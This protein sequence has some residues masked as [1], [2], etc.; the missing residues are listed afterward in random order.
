MVIKM[1]STTI[2]YLCPNCGAAL[3]YDAEKQKFSCEFCFSDFDETELSVSG[4]ADAADKKE[5]D[6]REFCDSM[7][8][9]YC[10]NCGADVIADEHTVANFCYYCH[11]PVILR[12][13][14]EG[15]FKPDKIIPFIIDKERAERDFLKYAKKKW[16]APSDFSDADHASK[17]SGIYYPFWVTDADTD[18]LLDGNAEKVR[19]WTS[20]NYRVTETSRYKVRRRGDIHFEDITSSAYSDADKEML[21]GILP[22]P[23]D[24]H[25]EFSMPY[26]LGFEAKKRDVERSSLT[27]EVRER[28]NRYAKTI[29]SDSVNGYN[30]FSVE[31]CNVS[32]KSSHWEYTFMPIWMLTYTNKNGKVYTYAMNG[33][34]GKVYGRVPVSV[35]K[36]L[37]FGAALFA[38]LCGTFILIGGLL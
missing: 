21:E 30:H 14:L 4:A 35:A 29:L 11:S 17:I 8:E 34:T 10:P 15:Q 7:N 18:C 26:L 23:S 32:V 1:K 9:Y 13:K 27:N 20:G 37:G 16:F 6:D 3:I 38:A 5:R 33:Y 28:M 12:G 2:T 24:C 22:Y 31:N 25:V 36:L 19:V